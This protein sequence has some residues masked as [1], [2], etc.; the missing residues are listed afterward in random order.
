MLSGSVSRKRRSTG[1]YRGDELLMN[2]TGSLKGSVAVPP[3]QASYRLEADTD[4]DGSV[5][6]LSTR[7][8]SVWT[9]GSAANGVQQLLPLVDVDYPDLTRGWRGPSALDLANTAK[10][11]DDVTLHLTG[12]HQNGA[13]AGA[14]A[15]MKVWVSYDDGA[16]WSAVPVRARG[17]EEFSAS[18]RHPLRGD[19]VS[20]RVAASDSDGNTL[21]QTLVR[22]YRLG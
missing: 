6:G 7:T 4:H 14:V 12:G 1:L 10:R 13:E 11:R 8:R 9:F 19:F 17:A 2:R 20:L 21:E 18:Y 15:S 5:L 22:A 3:E 16:T